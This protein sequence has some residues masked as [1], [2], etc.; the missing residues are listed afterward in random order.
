MKNLRVLLFYLAFLFCQW[1][2]CAA[3]FI[4]DG[5]KSQLSRF[6]ESLDRLRAPNVTDNRINK[7]IE[8]C[9]EEIQL[10]ENLLIKLREGEENIFNVIS[11]LNELQISLLDATRQLFHFRLFIAQ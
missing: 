11:C 10:C 1:H 4:E 8:K 2:F 7:R 6:S 5:I 9:E 3:D